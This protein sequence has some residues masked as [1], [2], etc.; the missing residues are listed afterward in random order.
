M[1]F[2]HNKSNGFGWEK[3]SNNKIKIRD[4]TIFN[5]NEIHKSTNIVI[6]I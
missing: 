2:S 6:I 3:N 1:I 4:E 5:T